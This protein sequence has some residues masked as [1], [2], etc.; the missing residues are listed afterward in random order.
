MKASI[1][2]LKTGEFTAKRKRFKTPQPATPEAMMQT[3]VKL[4]K[5]YFK[6][7]KNKKRNL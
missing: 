2:D 6:K 5:N 3:V 4:Q 1:V 7:Q